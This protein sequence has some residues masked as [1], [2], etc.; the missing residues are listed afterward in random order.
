MFLIRLSPVI[1]YRDLQNTVANIKVNTT[2]LITKSASS[3]V[4]W[5]E[6]DKYINFLANA[7]SQIQILSAT[8]GLAAEA[9]SQHTDVPGYDV[10]AE[11]NI[12]K[13]LCDSVILWMTTNLPKDGTGYELAFTRDT[14]GNK[15]FRSFST[16]QTTTLRTELQALID[17]IE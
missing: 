9:Q 13:S 16:A 12:V 14:Q 15:I 6:I 4:G 7:V 17:A 3:A 8:S 10:I 2:Y 11:Y 5:D 1:A